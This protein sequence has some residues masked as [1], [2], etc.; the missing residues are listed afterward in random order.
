MADLFLVRQQVGSAGES[1][2]SVRTDG[3]KP[4][5][6]RTMQRTWVFPPNDQMQHKGGAACIHSDLFEASMRVHGA[7]KKMG[8]KQ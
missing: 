1:W 7:M 2:Y 6:I 5:A 8:V 4:A 3:L